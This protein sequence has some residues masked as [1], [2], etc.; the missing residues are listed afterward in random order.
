MVGLD[1]L[2][3]LFSLNSSMTLRW[4][5]DLFI[6]AQC[7]GKRQWVQTQELLSG[8]IRK[9]FCTVWMTQHWH[10]LPREAVESP[11]RSVEHL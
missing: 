5:Q 2:I 4:S 1:D 8:S 11:W 6:G 9:H 10:R 3:D 7:Q